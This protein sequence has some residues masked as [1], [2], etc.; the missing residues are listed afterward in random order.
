MHT[1]SEENLDISSESEVDLGLGLYDDGF[2]KHN[3]AKKRRESL[4]DL[5]EP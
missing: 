4:S 1:I 5:M 2:M 3:K